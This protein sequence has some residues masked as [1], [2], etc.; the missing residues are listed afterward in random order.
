MAPTVTRTIASPQA[1]DVCRAACSVA[2]ALFIVVNLVLS[3]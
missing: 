2:L 3:D 1:A